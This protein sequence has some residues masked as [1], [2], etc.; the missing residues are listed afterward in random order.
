[1]LNAP[2]QNWPL[3]QSLTRDADA[4]WAQ[5]ETP[6]DRLALYANLFNLILQQRESEE[7]TQRLENLR[8][9]S[10]LA[11]RL[12]MVAAF[13]ISDRRRSDRSLANDSAI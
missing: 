6:A 13:A 8:W 5:Q 4:A 3:Y 9:Q 12:K 11:M 7:A 10:K 1:M 2:G